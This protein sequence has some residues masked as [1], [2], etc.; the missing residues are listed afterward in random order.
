MKKLFLGLAV[1]SAMV[2]GLTTQA[3][4]DELIGKIGFNPTASFSYD[5]TS[6]IYLDNN[7]TNKNSS[8]GKADKND[9]G[10]SLGLEYIFDE[11]I[12]KNI[13]LGLGISYF[14]NRKADDTEF[15]FFSLYGLAKLKTN[16]LNKTNNTPIF[17]Y[18]V[19]QIGLNMLD[20][21]KPWPATLGYGFTKYEAKIAGQVYYAFGAGIEISSFVVE[22][23]YSFNHIS[24]Q[25]T[26]EGFAA[27]Q[28]IKL[29]A[30]TESI[31]QCLTINVGYKFKL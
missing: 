18:G 23:L 4:S 31:Y 22:L 25:E 6:S 16:N 30:D 19:M 13:P 1:L 17:L 28:S 2:F 26:L 15:S 27:G 12:N 11:V 29:L 5:T 14:A 24:I 7:L 9:I 3:L 21:D 10:V 20:L 8:S